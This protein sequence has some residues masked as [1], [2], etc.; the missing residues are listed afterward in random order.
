MTPKAPKSVPK[1]Q[2]VACPQS[3]WHHSSKRSKTKPSVPIL[4]FQKM[5]K[6][7]LSLQR[8]K[9]KKPRFKL[10]PKLKTM[11]LI[12]KKRLK[13]IRVWC[14]P[15]WIWLE[16]PVPSWCRFWRRKMTRLS[17]RKLF[18]PLRKSRQKGRKRKSEN[19]AG[20]EFWRPYKHIFSVGCV[21]HKHTSCSIHII[22]LIRRVFKLNVQNVEL[23]LGKT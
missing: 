11:K 1:N 14:M 5:T 7:P 20:S 17:M 10:T 15:N 8:T 2:N 19:H 16:V 13:T 12:K 18:I 6:L 22:I 4:T 23:L 9:S 3:N 21:Q